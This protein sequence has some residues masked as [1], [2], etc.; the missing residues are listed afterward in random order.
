MWGR[1]L[2]GVAWSQVSNNV[3]G[4]KFP[5]KLNEIVTFLSE[6]LGGVGLDVTCGG[7]IDLGT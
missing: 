5:E 1:H 3:K 6:R 4:E 7:R 2:A